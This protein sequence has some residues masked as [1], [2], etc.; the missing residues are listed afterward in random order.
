MVPL[1]ALSLL[2]AHRGLFI[3]IGVALVAIG[4]LNIFSGGFGGWTIY[5]GAQI[6]WGVQEFRNFEMYA[7]AE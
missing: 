5:G 4:L 2:L 1:G 6:Y 3:A 7:D